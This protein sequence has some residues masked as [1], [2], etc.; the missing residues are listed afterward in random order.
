MTAIYKRE[1]AAYFHSF[2]GSLFIGATLFLIGI[3]FSVYDL[4][5]GYPYIGYALSSVVFLFLISIPVLAMR[6]LAE[7]KRQK[8][9]QLILTSPVSVS[10]IVVGKFLALATIFAIPVVIISF[11]PLILSF[12]GTVSFGESYLAISGFFLYGLACI[13]ICVFVSSLTE[14]QVIA[15]V[16]SFGI[17]FLGY[18]M[19]GLCNMISSTGNALTKFLDIFDMVGRFDDLLNGSLQL[20]SIVYYL[21]VTILFLIFTVQSVQKRR[22]Q[23][24]TRTI[25]MS[26]YSSSVVIISTA[27]AVLLNVI[28]GELP[29]RFTVF[30]MTA[31]QLYSLTD[32]TKNFLSGLEEEITIYVL[33]NEK[34][35]DTTLAA[36]LQDYRELSDQ[37]KINYVDPTV[38]PRFYTNYTD[39]M[40]NANSI[41]VE[42]SKRSKVIDYS[43][44]Y[45]SEIDYSTYSQT[46]T[47]YD[48]EGQLTSAI[49]YVT[50][51]E[52]PKA[53]ILEGH[54]E[55]I[56]DD[57]F[58]SV[59]EKQ[60]IDYEIIN[61]MNYDN[62]PEDASC[63]ILNAPT[64]DLSDDDTNKMIS[65]MEQ[66]GDVL[67][68]STYTGTSMP[69]LNRL[70]AFYDIS[71]TEGLI[72]EA[73]TN[74]YYQDQYFLLPEIS[75]DTVTEGVYDNGGYIFVPY[76][77]GL[78]VN[79]NEEISITP[80]LSASDSCYVRSSLETSASYEKQESDLEGPF[81]VGVKCE[82]AA[83]EDTST[84]LIYTSE[85]IFTKEA[86]VMVSGN[87]RRLFSGTLLSFADHTVSTAIPVK[88]YE[89]SYL[90]IS[91]S[92]L[93]TLALLTTII[94]PFSIL[95]AGFIIWFRR[96][97]R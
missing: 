9:D 70:L 11:Y 38:N 40:I 65:Y 95:T 6:I 82:K 88:S 85:G 81:Q 80:L 87:N 27:A 21:T 51:E 29:S 64:S 43:D 76:A 67:L 58:T 45:Q 32:D 19:S 84:G 97:K 2:I 47:G 25:S 14:S 48:G 72:I 61:L 74:Y 31:N 44:I 33:A 4:Y 17:L 53:Y 12:F 54:G 52:M 63:V 49:A 78:T 18:V 10:G 30:D 50:T 28:V 94:I 41:I 96:R 79:E 57:T 73:D 16:L 62:V 69:N 1:L 75:Y 46:I 68:I 13:A 39:S 36:T 7:E 92:T 22:Y 15:A 3:Y 66:G 55:L 93:V 83:G 24:T 35:A 23:V 71:I 34:Q 5:M 56:F 91:Q 90:T 20:T 8:T 59:I 77:Q 37:I 60:N 26:A 89:I 42:S 86:D